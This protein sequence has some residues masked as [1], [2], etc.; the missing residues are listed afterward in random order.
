MLSSDIENRLHFHVL[1]L[2]PPAVFP[3]IQAVMSHYPYR[4]HANSNPPLAAFECRDLAVLDELI[5]AGSLNKIKPMVPIE[6]LN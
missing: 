3:L 1:P 2:R 6:Y 4:I 5:K